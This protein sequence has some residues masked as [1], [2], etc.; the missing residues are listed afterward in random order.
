VT[1]SCGSVLLCLLVARVVPLAAQNA[2]ATARDTN[3]HQLNNNR[4]EVASDIRELVSRW[5]A[6]ES[7]D[8][9]PSKRVIPAAADRR[10]CRV[11]GA[12]S[13]PFVVEP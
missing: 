5:V 1:R 3:D 2:N 9:A 12:F 10:R 6:I 7:F 13:G 4:A 8:M 11:R